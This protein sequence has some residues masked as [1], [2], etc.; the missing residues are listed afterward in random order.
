MK[1][2]L[3]FART[4]HR[5]GQSAR[6]SLARVDVEVT[7]LVDFSSFESRSDRADLVRTAVRDGTDRELEG[8]SRDVHAAVLDA[9]LQVQSMTSQ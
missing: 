8:A 1:V 2:D 7:W 6:A 5:D 9:H 3:G 4:L